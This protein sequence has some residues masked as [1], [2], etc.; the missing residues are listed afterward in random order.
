MPAPASPRCRSRAPGWSASSRRFGVVILA[1][2]AYYGYLGYELLSNRWVDA[3]AVT[4]SVEEK[5]KAGWHASLAE[6]LAAAEREQKPV[7]DRHVGDLVQEL[8]DDGQDDA[9]RTPT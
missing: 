2:A 3:A 9:A 7:L 6:G 8:S 5:L 4:S 1:T